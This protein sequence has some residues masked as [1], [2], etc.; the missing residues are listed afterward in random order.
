MLQFGIGDAPTQ[1]MK[2]GIYVTQSNI[3][4]FINRLTEFR[5][6]GKGLKEFRKMFDICRIPASPQNP[7]LYNTFFVAT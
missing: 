2:N 5:N 1:P 7:A 6:L 4:T 3:S